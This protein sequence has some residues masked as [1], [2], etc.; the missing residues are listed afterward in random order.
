LLAC[1][2]G[3]QRPDYE[4]LK[5]NKPYKFLISLNREVITMEDEQKINQLA[6]TLFSKGL[7]ASMW[8]AKNKAR[9]ILGL[10]AQKSAEMNQTPEPATDIMHDLG[11][12]DEEIH[13]AEEE[14]IEEI[15]KEFKDII[16]PNL[17]A[18][19]GVNE[20]ALEKSNDV[21][22]Q[23]EPMETSDELETTEVESSETDAQES[24]DNAENEQNLEETT[25][26]TD[27]EEIERE[28]EA[29]ETGDTEEPEGQDVEFVETTG[30]E[31]GESPDTTE[32]TED[33]VE[34][35]ESPE[36]NTSEETEAVEPDSGESDE[37]KV[38]EPEETEHSQVSVEQEVEFV[39]TTEA[40]EPENNQ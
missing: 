39:E 16:T 30:V 19:M 9:D 8:D 17:D 13:K 38:E 25:N 32:E 37:T 4:V 11:I 5:N 7:S 27:S 31:I 29:D 22:N 21:V 12:S 6:N 20:A 28:P 34:V 36:T 10:T 33:T 15:K 2:K 35:S 14:K 1:K 26:E 23:E 18:D 40:E 24:D 3:L